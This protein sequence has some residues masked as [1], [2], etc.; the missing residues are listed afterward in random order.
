VEIQQ[1]DSPVTIIPLNCGV[2]GAKRNYVQARVIVNIVSGSK[3]ANLWQEQTL[4]D[5]QVGDVEVQTM[6]RNHKMTI[7]GCFIT[8]NADFTSTPASPNQDFTVELTGTIYVNQ[9]AL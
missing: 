8:K 3:K 7:T 4:N 6:L 5:C 2:D 9:L 1:Q